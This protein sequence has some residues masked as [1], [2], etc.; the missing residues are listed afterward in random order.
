MSSSSRLHPYH[1]CSTPSLRYP[2]CKPRFSINLVSQSISSLISVSSLFFS[3]PPSHLST[4]PSFL[5][6][7]SHL[8]TLPYPT[9]RIHRCPTTQLF[10]SSFT[11]PQST[12][13]A[14]PCFPT[15]TRQTRPSP[16]PVPISIPHLP[17]PVKHILM[18]CVPHISNKCRLNACI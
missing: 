4:M 16:S 10:P 8:P 17:S 1:P 14:P 5:S 13:A 9:G 6:S 11:P 3:H 18:K 15:S 7:R 12:P 2:Q